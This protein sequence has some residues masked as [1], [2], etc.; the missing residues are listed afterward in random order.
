M[1]CEDGTAMKVKVE[2]VFKSTIIS[3]DKAV[4]NSWKGK[5]EKLIQKQDDMH[6]SIEEI[7]SETKISSHQ[8]EEKEEEEVLE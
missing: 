5:M 8:G 3:L 4:K 7:I 1:P 6:D 2:E